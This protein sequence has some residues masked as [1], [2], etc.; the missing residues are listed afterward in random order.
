MTTII[1]IKTP[2]LVKDFVIPRAEYEGKNSLV[3][4]EYNVFFRYYNDE[5]DEENEKEEHYTN[6]SFTIDTNLKQIVFWFL[7]FHNVL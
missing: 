5:T 3:Q 4:L 2:S 1:I 7:F 6:I